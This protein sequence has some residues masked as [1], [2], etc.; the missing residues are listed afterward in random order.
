MA[1][2]P[3][4]TTKIDAIATGASGTHRRTGPDRTVSR[5]AAG[6]LMPCTMW[7]HAH[8]SK[9]PVAAADRRASGHAGLNVMAADPAVRTAKVSRIQA[10]V[11]NGG[12]AR[13]HPARAAPWWSTTTVA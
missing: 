8:A 11:R 12:N 6:T 7:V 4:T 2:P 1:L 9:R 5:V 13:H 10:D 3:I